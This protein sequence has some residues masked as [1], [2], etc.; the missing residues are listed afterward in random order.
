LI[1]V[2]KWIRT[3]S[4]VGSLRSLAQVRSRRESLQIKRKE[5][6]RKE[7]KRKTR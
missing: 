5:K 2:G 6:K 4:K 3:E 1:K 7:K